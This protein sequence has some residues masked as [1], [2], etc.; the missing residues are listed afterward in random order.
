MARRRPAARHEIAFPGVDALVDRDV[1]DGR[2]HVVVAGGVD[3]VGRLDRVDA[4]RVRHGAHRPLRGCAVEPDPPAEVIVR[5]DDA[6]DDVRIGDRGLGAA[7][8]V[9]GRARH[10]A[11]A[12]RPD[13]QQPAHVD[14]GDA[15][16]AGADGA[17][18]HLGDS[19]AVVAEHRLRRNHQ[20]AGADRRDIEG[21]AAH[22]DDDDVLLVGQVRGCDR[23]ERR[24]RH[25]AVDRLTQH[26]VGRHHAADAVG[27][28]KLLAEAGVRQAVAQLAHVGA[29]DGGAARRRS[30]P[31]SCAGTRAGSG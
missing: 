14:P 15:A 12:L 24:A 6:Q 31:R 18:V 2:D 4:E 7:L 19:E 5:V 25:H 9:A 20:P 22:V 1:L 3:R 16:A 10:G 26:L 29:D 23:R 13:V 27:E 11:G 8:A 28:Q 17:H 30:R 21:G